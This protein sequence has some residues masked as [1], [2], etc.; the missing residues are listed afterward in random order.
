MLIENVS[1]SAVVAGAS[2]V[3]FAI[4]SL[5][6]QRHFVTKDGVPFGSIVI[7]LSAISSVCVFLGAIWLWPGDR[8]WPIALYVASLCLFVWTVRTTRGLDFL[9]AYAGAV[10]QQ[11]NSNGPYRWVRHPFYV[12]YLLYHLGNALA[13]NSYVPYLMFLLMTAIYIHAARGEERLL[14]QGDYAP[15][16][17]AY[18]RRTGMFAPRLGWRLTGD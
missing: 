17:L 2:V 12:S 14:E 15:D 13:T 6:A 11:F 5:L 7:V 16:Y 3:T 10:P 9:A 1:S 8:Y 18:R 4:I